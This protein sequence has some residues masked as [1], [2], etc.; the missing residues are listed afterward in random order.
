M[1]REAPSWQVAW[2]TGASSGIGRE[3]ALLLARRGVKV[4]VTARSA[5]K[6]AELA[7]ISANIAA[8]PAD[9]TDG[10]AIAA[11]VPEI[12]VRLGAVDLAILNAGTWEQVSVKALDP[13][14]FERTFDVNFHGV[15]RSLAAVLPG[16]RARRRGRIAIVASVAGYRGLPKAAAYGPSKAALINLA[17]SL[18]PE[19][20]RDGI[21]LCLVNPGFVAT[22]LTAKNDFPMPYMIPPEDAA[23]RIIAGLE[24]GRFEIAFPW[25]L[26]AM[27]KIARILPYRL[28]F[29]LVRR[30]MLRE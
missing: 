29:A 7:E 14:V 20:G 17:E 6:L 10:Q 13:A 3:L 23:A 11:L 1:S 18:S 28:F 16:M 8:F 24:R 4:A 2:V 22:P 15:V 26:V 27:L 30:G 12:E 25:Q 21:G 19:L 5:G 9:V